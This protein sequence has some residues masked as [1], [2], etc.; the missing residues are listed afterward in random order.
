[1]FLPMPCKQAIGAFRY[2]AQSTAKP[3]NF[4]WI[5]LVEFYEHELEEFEAQVALIKQGEV[6]LPARPGSKSS[7]R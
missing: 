5:H 7:A 3:A 2:A 6:D 1:M 4:H